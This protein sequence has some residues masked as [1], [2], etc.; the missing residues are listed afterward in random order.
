[1]CGIVGKFNY[2][3]ID[4]NEFASKIQ[5]RGPDQTTYFINDNLEIAFHRLAIMGISN[6][7]QPFL[8]SD[9]SIAVFVNGEIYNYKEIKEKYFSTENFNTNSDC[10][11]VLKLYQKFSKN[12]YQLL[13]GMFMIIIVDKI[14]NKIYFMRDPMGEKPLYYYQNTNSFIFSSEFKAIATEK[15][16]I[17]T[18]NYE[19]VKDYMINGYILEPKTLFN[20]ILKIPKCSIGE[21]DLKKNN[22]KFDSYW[23]NTFLASAKLLDANKFFK[24]NYKD[25]FKN[26]YNSDVDIAIAFSSGIDSNFITHTCPNKKNVHLFHVCFKGKE[27]YDERNEAIKFSKLHKLPL[28]LVEIDS[29]D[30]ENEFEEMVYSLDEP[31]ADPTSFSYFK[32]MKSINQKNLKVLIMGHG[33][34]EL[35]WGYDDIDEIYN[36]HS[37]KK[38]W[39]YNLFYYLKTKS[40]FPKT[41]KSF[42]MGFIDLFGFKNAFYNLFIFFLEKKNF[43]FYEFD[44]NYK[45]IL[46]YKNN[47]FTSFF[48]KNISFQNNFRYNNSLSLEKNIHDHIFD[49]YLLC[50]GINQCERLSMSQSIELRLPFIQKNLTQ[51]FYGVKSTGSKKIIKDI[52]IENVSNGFSIAKKRG[53][54]PPSHIWDK[55]I[56]NKF[57]KLLING[58]LVFNKIIKEE[59]IKKIINRKFDKSTI[60]LSY[61]LIILEILL[62]KYLS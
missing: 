1:M 25:F 13:E 6:G 11:V 2:P 55:L 21:Y 62:R 40:Y 31:I 46:K 57:G 10:E 35:L 4:I 23:S 26:I 51:L 22:I 17:K 48:L 42:I 12:F 58:Q 45:K 34:D 18:I 7:S 19:A 36:I 14:L 52:L 5:H 41:L 32:L 16:I 29:N 3:Q 59:A 47:I 30:L 33:G 20:E 39:I 43:L 38:K 15:N 53:F 54:S 56:I 44:N 50:N 24:Q 27:N 28:E 37:I 9:K 8:N 49:T 60:S 61:K